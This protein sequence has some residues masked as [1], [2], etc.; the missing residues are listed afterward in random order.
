[1]MAEGHGKL[2]AYGIEHS[3]GVRLGRKLGSLP[4]VCPEE[5]DSFVACIEL[6]AD[7][8]AAEDESDYAS[9]HVLVDAG[10]W[11]GLDVESRLFADFAA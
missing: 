4:I 8:F 7:Y 6:A 1:M 5:G 3:D 10:E 11:P 9:D 2:S